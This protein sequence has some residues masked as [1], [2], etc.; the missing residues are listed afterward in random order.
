MDVIHSE[1]VRGEICVCFL[2]LLNRIWT[3]KNKKNWEMK[4]KH[5]NSGENQMTYKYN[6]QYK[7]SLVA[8]MCSAAHLHFLLTYPFCDFNFITGNIFWDVLITRR[9]V[10]CRHCLL[11]VGGTTNLRF[12]LMWCQHFF[13]SCKNPN[14]W[15]LIIQHI[16]LRQ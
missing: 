9:P 3:H 16:H 8:F 1:S 4:K 10:Y 6:L 13:S 5:K 7:R 14:Q 15:A 11:A 2:T 12:F